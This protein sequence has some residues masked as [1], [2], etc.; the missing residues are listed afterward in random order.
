MRGQST[1]IM[2]IVCQEVA[3]SRKEKPHAVCRMRDRPLG[4]CFQ[5]WGPN[6][7]WEMARSFDI[8]KKLV[9]QAYLRVKANKGAEGVDG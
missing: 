8:S 9:W 1:V 5:E 3:A 2:C 7:P 4:L 6:R